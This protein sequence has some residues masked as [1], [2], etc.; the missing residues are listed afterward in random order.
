MTP[1]CTHGTEDIR[2]RH[3]ISPSVHRVIRLYVGKAQGTSIA[4]GPFF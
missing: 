2:H 1:A 4:S 3:T